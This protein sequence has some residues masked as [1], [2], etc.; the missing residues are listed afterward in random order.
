MIKFFFLLFS[1]LILV[2]CSRTS[3]STTYVSGKGDNDLYIN[4]DL[5][6]S[7][8][9]KYPSRLYPRFKPK[10]NSRI[11]NKSVKLHQLKVRSEILLYTEGFDK[12]KDGNLVEY[13]PGGLSEKKLFRK[14]KRRKFLDVHT[15]KDGL[16]R[17]EKEVNGYEYYFG[18]RLEQ[19]EKGTL[20]LV[21]IVR[22][23]EFIMPN[24]WAKED[25]SDFDRRVDSSRYSDAE[26]DYIEESYRKGI[27]QGLW[28]HRMSF[29]HFDKLPKDKSF[30]EM[31]DLF[32]QEDLQ[33]NYSRLNVVLNNVLIDTIAKGNKESRILAQTLLSYL[34]RNEDISKLEVTKPVDLGSIILDSD[35]I[36][37][38]DLFAQLKEQDTRLLMIN[39]T[40]YWSQCRYQASK[41]LDSLRESGFNTIF[42][43]GVSND[44]AINFVEDVEN[45]ISIFI[46]DPTFG[47][48]LKKAAS[49]GF[50]IYGYDIQSV[51]I[52]IKGRSKL[53]AENIIKIINKKQLLKSDSRAIVYYGSQGKLF[54]NGRNSLVY[55]LKNKLEEKVLS[56]DQALLIGSEEIVVKKKSLAK[57]KTYLLRSNE[58]KNRGCDYY[59]FESNSSYFTN[60][61]DYVYDLGEFKVDIE[62]YFTPEVSL[63]SIYT[64]PLYGYSAIP[65]FTCSRESRRDNLKLSK[66]TYFVRR[67]NDNG[68]IV[69]GENL[70]VK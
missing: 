58:L 17:Y 69:K 12:D 4:T 64:K 24:M 5:K 15:D 50:T 60:A 34:S 3:Y 20:R 46:S 61:P 54:D 51:D 62:K 1:M 11:L 48:F 52:E 59:L 27:K 63:I 32:F 7:I 9:Q 21:G 49:L 16:I 70:D 26:L 53:Q 65:I 44:K 67:F 35:I 10:K 14:L 23:G 36:P 55:Q 30:N 68:Q 13:Y 2:S 31:N 8:R 40:H 19:L 22:K 66:G 6:V 47:N 28:S 33:Y 38:D 37:V 25:L 42:L 56:I 57:N 39:E 41:L 43:E 18:E 29:S 45:N